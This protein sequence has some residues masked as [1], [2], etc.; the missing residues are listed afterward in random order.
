M[1][2]VWAV[3][4]G[5]IINV[6]VTTDIVYLPL[7]HFT[8][9]WTYDVSPVTIKATKLNRKENVYVQ[10]LLYRKELSLKEVKVTS[11]ELLEDKQILHL[12][13]PKKE[14]RCPHC[15]TRT[16]RIKDYRQQTVC[17][18]I[19]NDIPVYAQF[20]KRQYSCPACHYPSRRLQTGLRKLSTSWNSHGPMGI[21]GMHR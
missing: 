3:F 4:F 20:R 21:Q 14:Q 12:A 9:K 15:H 13:I 8:K 18:A 16:S 1:Q 19:A 2:F 6:G 17:I 10:F 7:P 11:L 5:S